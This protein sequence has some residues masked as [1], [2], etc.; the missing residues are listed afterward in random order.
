[1]E[2]IDTREKGLKTF[3][4]LTGRYLTLSEL[5]PVKSGENELPGVGESS[6]TRVSQSSTVSESIGLCHQ[7]LDMELKIYANDYC[8]VYP[9]KVFQI[10]KRL[11]ET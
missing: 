1:M 8:K 3:Y 9:L 6:S 11:L 2:H 4:V 5:D 7:N 10:Q